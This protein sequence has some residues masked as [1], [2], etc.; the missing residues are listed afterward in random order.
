M[1]K[2]STKTGGQARRWPRLGAGLR[3]TRHLLEMVVAM[4]A[5]M[6]VLG[7]ALGVLGEP[8]AT[9]TRLSSTA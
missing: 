8:P 2:G 6:A 1:R 3:F 7:V 4:I 5:G 9:T